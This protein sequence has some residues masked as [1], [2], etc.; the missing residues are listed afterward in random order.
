MKKALKLINNKIGIGLFCCL[1]FLLLGCKGTSSKETVQE[2]VTVQVQDAVLNTEEQEKE[3]DYEIQYPM[4]VTDQIGRQVTIE[5]EP[6][7]IVSGYYISTSLLI[8]LG[9]EE[10]MVG[11]ENNPEI[12]P[13]YEKSAPHLLELPQVGTV[14]ELDLEQCALLQPDLMVL[15]FK[16][17]DTADSLEQLGITVLYVKPESKEL[18]DETISLLGQV[19]NIKERASLLQSAIATKEKEMAELVEGCQKPTVYLTGNSNFLTTAGKEMYQHSLVEMAGGKNVAEE[20]TGFS[21]SE[22]SY[23]QLL[24]WDPEYIVLA[25]NAKFDVESVLKD[26][27][28]AACQAVKNGNVYQFPNDIESWDSPVPGS[29]LGGLWLAS[30]LHPECY[31]SSCYEASV[32][33]FYQEFYDINMQ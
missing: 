24:A 14:K 16:L 9:Q 28:L 25:A 3:T 4:I 30:I 17:K 15:P 5:E 7:T 20:L 19:L 6:Q 27:N 23:E 26:E 13:I 33:E 12:R 21:W 2:N 32:E 31:D 29:V 18:L 8:A 22:I 11:I 10:K 1:F